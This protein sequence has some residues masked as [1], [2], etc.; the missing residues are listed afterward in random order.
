MVRGYYFGDQGKPIVAATKQLNYLLNPKEMFARAYAQY[1]AI[2]S[3]DLELLK[4]V[5]GRRS[6]KHSR[7]NRAWE[8]DEF[9]PV[10][11][12]IEQVLRDLGMTR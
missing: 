3:G 5:G 10:A 4:Q 8:D 12:A 6:G 2:S 11:A 7:Y 9:E 1:T